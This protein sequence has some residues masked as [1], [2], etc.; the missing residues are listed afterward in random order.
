GKLVLPGVIDAHTHMAA[1]NYG[2]SSSDDFLSGTRA[3]ACGGVTTIIDFT[4]GA[5]ETSIPE[6]IEARKEEA[7]PS[8]IDYALHAEVI[9][10]K[11]GQGKELEE[12]REAGV[13]SFKFY[14]AYGSLGQ[15]A[16]TG[17]LYHAFRKIE[18]IDGVAMVHAE[19]DPIIESLV[20]NLSPEQRATMSAYPGTRPAVCEGAAIEQAI[21]LAEQT[22]ARLHVVHVSS[23]LGLKAIRQSRSRG[24]WVSG[25]TCPQYLLLTEDIYQQEDGHQF[26]VMPP[27]RTGADQDSLWSALRDGTLDLVATDHCPFT[28]EQKTWNGSFLDLPYGLPGVETLLPLLYSEGVRKECIPLTTLPRLLS[29]GP[30]R[31]NGLYPRKGALSIGA[32]ADIVIFDP[33]KEWTIH[34]ENLRMAT[35]FSPY[36]GMTVHGAVETAISRGRIVYANETFQG[37]EGWGRFIPC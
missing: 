35:D 3:A 37:E 36:E 6:E 26:S 13:R 21:Y 32:D 27:L 15:R 8:V 11:P 12:A 5:Q 7:A 16:D 22:R 33:E 19:D 17:V 30:A 23:A 20:A 2:I 29:E 9:G 28:R 4:V 10:W 25:E 31:V 34:A 24:V 18:E 14:M 1:E